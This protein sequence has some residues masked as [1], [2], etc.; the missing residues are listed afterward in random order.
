MLLEIT[1]NKHKA[2]SVRDDNHV[3]DRD[4]SKRPLFGSRRRH[5]G[6]WLLLLLLIV[7]GVVLFL[8]PDVVKAVLLA[9]S[10]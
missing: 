4:W 3:G 7:V 10:S 5:M 9:F 6:R 1:H 2:L 8:F